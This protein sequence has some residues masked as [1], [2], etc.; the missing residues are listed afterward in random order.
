LAPLEL[1][2]KVL[3]SKEY[4]D[5]DHADLDCVDCHGGNSEESDRVTAHKGV[6]KDPTIK[7]AGKVCGDCHEEIVESAS[8]SIHADIMLKKNALKPRTTSNLWE[9]KVDAASSNHCMKCHA[10]C[11]QCHVSRTENVGS[12]FIKG[13]VFQKRPDMVSQCTACHGSRIGKE[14]FGERGAG[15]VH[16]TEKNMDCVDCH[17]ADEMHAKSQKNIKNRF[18]VQEI[19]ACTDCH[20]DVKKGSPIKQHD[21]H[22]G[23]VQCQICHAQQYVNCFNCHVGKDPEGLAY[24]KNGKEIETF[25][26]GINPEKTKSFPYNYMLVRNVPANPYLLDYYGKDLLP[27]FDKVHTWKRTAPHNIQRK[28]WVSE[29]CNHCHGNRDIFLDKKDIQYDFLLK[30]NRPIL[31][32]DSMVPERQDEGKI[33]QRPTV[34]VRNDLV[35]DASWLHKNIAN[36]DLIIVDTRSRRNYM[37]GHI[38][39]AIYINVFNLRQKNSWKAVNYIKAPKDLVKVFGS[40]GIDKNT[41]VIVYDDGSLKAGLLIFV[42]NYLGN[43]NVSYLDG[44]VEAWEDAGYHFVKDVPVKSAAKPFVPEVHAE[45]LADHLFFQKNLDNPGVRIVDVR[46]VAQY[47][48]LPGKSSAKLRWG[49]H[50]K[51]ML[52]LPC[53]VFY[54]DNGFLRN[55]DET[56][57]MLKQRGITHDKTVVLSCNTNQFAASAYAALRYLG[58]ED[59]RLHNGSMVSYERNC[60]PDMGH[61]AKMLQSGKQAFFSGRYLDAKE[62]FRKAVQADPSGTDA[63]KYYDI[64]INFALAEK[65]EKGSNINLLREP[66]RIDEGPDTVVTPPAP[67]SKDTKFKIEEDEGC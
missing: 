14:Y 11:G 39:N 16:L 61:S 45:I 25:K 17:D 46:S 21:I 4:F 42:L 31:V 26:I 9:S 3:I 44:G 52:N 23:K 12:G 10:S 35:V 29:S 41:H 24:Y 56:M 5:T 20:K 27:N 55:P 47:L 30:A 15:D 65:L 48:N 38:P 1:W 32:P 19:P 6:V 66:T 22:A 54:M 53:R 49:G 33:T 67:P 63:W 8:Q 18:D 2:E 7:S 58:F 62:Y 43:D 50:L 40:C 36:Q 64:I 37:D 57:F 59:V 28:T 60:L 13:H 51:G 34:K